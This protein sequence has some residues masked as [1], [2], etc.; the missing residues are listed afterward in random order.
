MYF[1]SAKFISAFLEHLSL[2]F[3]LLILKYKINFKP[4]LRLYW[5]TEYA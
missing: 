4:I 1:S 3:D 2:L 5:P